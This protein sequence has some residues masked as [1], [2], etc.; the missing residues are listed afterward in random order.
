MPASKK[1]H[2]QTIFRSSK[3]VVDI[4]SFFYWLT[5]FILSGRSSR[6]SFLISRLTANLMY[7]VDASSS[8]GKWFKTEHYLVYCSIQFSL[9]ICGKI[10][11]LDQSTAFSWKPALIYQR[12]LHNDDGL[13]LCV[14]FQ[15]SVRE[16]LPVC[17][18]LQCFIAAI[19]VTTS[20]AK[21]I[22]GRI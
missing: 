22:L 1:W 10:F 9:P 20:T 15:G 4:I 21:G 11:T 13:Q 2:R 7:Q 17:G 12:V 3:V 6:I 14:I 18:C 8:R 19:V 16:R 5:V